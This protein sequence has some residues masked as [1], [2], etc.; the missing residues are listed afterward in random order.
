VKQAESLLSNQFNR[1][2]IVS[3]RVFTASFSAESKNP[4]QLSRSIDDADSFVKLDLQ[5]KQTVLHFLVVV[6]KSSVRA[7][8][9]LHAIMIS[10]G[11]PKIAEGFAGR[12]VRFQSVSRP[13]CDHPR[14]GGV[15]SDPEI[16]CLL[17]L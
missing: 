7:L 5:V 9:S 13:I 10:Q 12:H 15:A 8:K 2:S 16:A 4:D 6:S 17:I 3:D 14:N 1:N 11:A